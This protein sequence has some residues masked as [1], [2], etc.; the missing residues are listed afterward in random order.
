MAPYEATAVPW[1]SATESIAEAAG[2]LER[3]PLE[4]QAI[5]AV[6]LLAV[7]ALVSL[8]WYNSRAH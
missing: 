4:R 3:F 2:T 6:A 7:V 8:H 1:P 5:V